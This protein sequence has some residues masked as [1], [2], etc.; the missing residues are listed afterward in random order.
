M[1]QEISAT[2]KT[3]VILLHNFT[4]LLASAYVL[5]LSKESH[6]ILKIWIVTLTSKVRNFQWASMLVIL[7]HNCY[8]FGLLLAISVVRLFHQLFFSRF[9]SILRYFPLTVTTSRNS[10]TEKIAEYLPFTLVLIRYVPAVNINYF[11]TA[12]EGISSRRHWL[13]QVQGSNYSLTNIS[14][15][16]TIYKR[17]YGRVDK[18]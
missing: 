10:F 11:A 7:S 14:Q 3:R 1:T 9:Y 8:V 4:R 15:S 16:I 12:T 5:N 17:I 18:R 2:L 6:V 13:C